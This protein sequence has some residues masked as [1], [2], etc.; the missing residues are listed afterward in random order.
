MA[1]I[2]NNE[3]SSL[4]QIVREEMHLLDGVQQ[5][6]SSSLRSTHLPDY[7]AALIRLREQL[8]DEHLPDDRAMILD[9]MDRLSALAE[10]RERYDPALPDMDSPYFAHLGLITDEGNRRDILLGKNTYIKDGVSIVDWR[11]APV[12]QIF[13][14][15]REGEPFDEEI[16]ERPMR[17]EVEA[18]RTITIS[19]GQ[20]TR[21]AAPGSTFLRI[22]DRWHEHESTPL[23][24]LYGGEGTALRPESA[25]PLLGTPGGNTYHRSDKHLPEIAA[26]LDAKQF[27]L[28]TANSSSLLVVSGG[29]GSG[30]TTVALHRL[31]Y[32]NFQN[33]KRFQPKR[34]L[35]LVFGLA[36]ARYIARV[37]PA[38]GVENVEVRT[39]ERWTQTVFRMH[40]RK[41][42]RHISPN[43]PATV[44]R[45]KT[46]RIMIPMLEQAAEAAPNADPV[47]LFNELFTDKAWISRG[48]HHHAPGSF[49][50]SEIETIHRWCVDELFYREDYT[51]ESN[52]DPPCYDEE[53]HMILLRLYQLLEGPL[54][55]SAGRNLSYH[56]LVIDEVQD[57][58]P[59]ELLVLLQTVRDN[60][61]T[62]SGDPA[63][64]ITDNDFSD[65]SEV[66]HLIGQDPIQISPLKVGYRSTREIMDFA[67]AVL[68]DLVLDTSFTSVRSGAGV[69]WFQFHGQGEAI[70]FIGDALEDLA[71]R[72]PDA[73]IAVLTRTPEQ[74][75]EAYAGLSRGNLPRLA[76]IRYQEFSFTPGIDVTEVAQTKGL[77]FDYVI[78]LNLDQ[79]SYSD[80][81]F[82]R[83]LL[84]VG[85]TRAIH[86]LWLLSW[87]APSP[88]LPHWLT[89]VLGTDC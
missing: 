57:F 8:A 69:E 78:L 18:R 74:A 6:I 54:R 45:F 89:P 60:S 65:W 84:H 28:L 20:L 30:K 79:A 31:A 27:D 16:A 66:L 37:L 34:M 23:T 10:T 26:L 86:Q 3:S 19:G 67:R 2:K 35:V 64:K 5:S 43:T 11:D 47:S 63:Q 33:P 59:L 75:D 81:A 32:L 49:S 72:E 82:D 50:D 38:L 51:P 46:H 85:A 9:Q 62:L 76:R 41:L 80:T 13:Y 25:K 83:H 7:G 55:W 1:Q 73:S 48:I 58:G 29:A 44:V 22:D 12:S 24:K 52:A 61:V 21:V 39:M 42:A 17:G 88:L 40:F 36:L 53:D 70:T 87:D 56:H 4:P 77:E 14:R 71:G 68:G 15:Y